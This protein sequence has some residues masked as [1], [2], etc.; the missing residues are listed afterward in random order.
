[1]GATL[2]TQAEALRLFEY[3]DGDLYWHHRPL[4]DFKTAA[5]CKSCNAQRAGTKAGSLN[6]GYI[7]V[8]V[9]GRSYGVHRLIWLMHHG[10]WPNRI[11]HIDHNPLN[12]NLNN[13]RSVT[14]KENHHNQGKRVN[15]KSGVTGIYYYHNKWYASIKNNGKNI[16]LG[17]FT[18]KEDA[19]TARQQA[20]TDLGYHPN[21]GK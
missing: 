6:S 20:E 16:H 14:H 11:D 4:Q 18:N 12:N 2:L 17:S 21:H 15:N 7:V 10:R 5:S 13:L 19:I 9:N 8:Q 3:R 1:M